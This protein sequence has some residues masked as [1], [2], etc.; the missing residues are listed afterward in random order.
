MARTD[1]YVLEALLTFDKVGVLVHELLAIE[2][3]KE[4]TSTV[5]AFSV[6]ASIQVLRIFPFRKYAATVQCGVPIYRIRV[7]EAKHQTR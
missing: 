1:E 4:V 3:W 5:E 2:V 6:L 7:G